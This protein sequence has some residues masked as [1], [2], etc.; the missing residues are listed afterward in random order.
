[1]VVYTFNPPTTAEGRWIIELFAPWL[2]PE[3][4]NPAAPGEVRYFAQVDGKEVEVES[5]DPFEHSGDTI[6]PR[7][8]TFIPARVDDN[9]FL[10][11]TNYKAQL[12]ALPEPLRSQM[13]KGDFSAGMEDDPWQVIPTQWV[14]LAQARWKTQDKPAVPCSC[15]GV[16]VA[17]GGKDFT[18]LAKRYGHWY[19]E[20]DKHAGT[21]TPNGPAVAAL[22]ARSARDDCTINVDVIGVGSAVYDALCAQ[23]GINVRGINF[24]ERSSGC[25]KSGKLRFV[26]LRAE[27]YWKFR[28]ALDP[29]TGDD[30]ALPPDS[31]LLSDLCA[32][33][34][35]L[36]VRGIKIEDKEEIKKR[37]GRSP[38]S[39]DAVV[40]GSDPSAPLGFVTLEE[41]ARNT[42]L[43]EEQQAQAEAE[44][45]FGDEG[46]D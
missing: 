32:P 21:S 31:Q 9:I 43:T 15:M 35:S 45:M 5:P 3:H 19:D 13:L 18:I 42:E 20:L 25:D 44:R 24:A 38:D 2:D 23:D 22:V 34:W 30:I 14:R 46:W 8:R 4:P 12:Q 39:G 11:Q 28:E 26:N 29:E 7:S 1:M 33:K 16:D 6:E 40:L 27:Y 36:T 17:R 37:L 10:A 41:F